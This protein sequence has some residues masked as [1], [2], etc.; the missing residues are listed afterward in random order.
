MYLI[1]DKLDGYIEENNGNKYL[2]L[3]V[4]DKNIDTLKK[5]TKL[6]D[7]IKDLIRLMTNTSGDYD[8]KYKKTKFNSDDNLLLDKI[9]KFII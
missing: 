2:T 8:E 5:Y 6:W 1:I 9:L 4:N 3:I 7:K